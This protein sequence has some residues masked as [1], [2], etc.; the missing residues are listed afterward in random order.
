MKTNLIDLII[1]EIVTDETTTYEIKHEELIETYNNAS[2]EA[3]STIDSMFIALT[4]WKFS[5]LFEMVKI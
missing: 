5:S 2:I 3:R 4:G 1:S